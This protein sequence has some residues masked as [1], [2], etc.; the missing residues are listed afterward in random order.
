[1]LTNSIRSLRTPVVSILAMAMPFVAAAAMD[2][3]EVSS[4]GIGIVTLLY[5]LAFCLGVGWIVHQVVQASRRYTPEGEAAITVVAGL[6]VAPIL[7]A[8]LFL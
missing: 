3:P 2:Q 4:S 1:M 7:A 6:F 8:F 5:C